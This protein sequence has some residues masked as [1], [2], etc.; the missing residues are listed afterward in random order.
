MPILAGGT[1]CLFLFSSRITK[2]FVVGFYQIL[3]IDTLWT[4][5]IKL[6]KYGSDVECSLG[7]LYIVSKVK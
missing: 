6:V 2:N 5:E 1:I 4:R 7:F 3:G